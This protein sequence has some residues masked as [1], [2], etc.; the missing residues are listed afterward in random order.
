MISSFLEIFAIGT[1]KVKDLKYTTNQ[2]NRSYDTK[3]HVDGNDHGNFF[4]KIILDKTNS[5][6]IIDPLIHDCFRGLTLPADLA[7]HPNV[8]SFSKN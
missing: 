4:I 7:S 1:K 8:G 5:T 6:L 3:M 2:L